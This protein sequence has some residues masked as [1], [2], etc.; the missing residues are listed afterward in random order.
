MKITSLR[1]TFV[2][3]LFCCFLCS[4]TAA[5]EGT[6]ISMTGELFSRFSQTP[7]ISRDAYLGVYANSIVQGRGTVLS[8]D[9]KGRYKR[10]YRL[11]LEEAETL[12]YRIRIIYNVF[13]ENEDTISL[14]AAGAVFEFRGQLMTCTPLNT[15]RSAY[16]F[17][18]V[19]Q[20]GALVLQ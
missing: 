3:L 9:Q 5:E 16:M 6:P 11:V 15:S 2:S 17:D 19:L 1:R 13:L 12:P 8:S 7:A 10:K 4:A 14:L 20:E 18:I